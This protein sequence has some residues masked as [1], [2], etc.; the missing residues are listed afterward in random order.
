MN[1]RT[2]L[3][4]MNTDTPDN[5]ITDAA[6]AAA[7]DDTHLICL[8]LAPLSALPI[9]AYGVPPYGGM[10]IP[11]NWGDLVRAEQEALK[12]RCDAIE[13]LLSNSN[14]SG[15]VVSTLCATLD[16]GHHVARSARV[17]DEAFV[18]LNLRDTPDFLR[19]AASGVLFNSPVGLRVNG[20]L[21]GANERVFVAWDSSKAASA[22]AHAALPYLTEANEVLI[23]CFDPVMTADR[24]GE[25]P[26]ADIAAW[27]SHHGCNVT[28]S[29]Y[30]SGG[31]EVGKCI[32]DRAQEFGADLIVMGAYGHSRMIQTVLGGTTRSMME[33]TKLPVLFAH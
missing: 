31:R 22:A 26:G 13:I 15:D 2:I 23:G 10:N 4:V 21:A 30:P 18:A 5:Q 19:E 25:E 20:S 33:Q 3:F 12:D 7:R 32:Q 1:C 11:D 16:V 6:E 24:D 29:Q 27:L 14:A 9:Y 8:V 17:C 28:V